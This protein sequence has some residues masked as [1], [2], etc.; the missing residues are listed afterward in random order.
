VALS[1]FED[2]S[3]LVTRY[4]VETGRETPVRSSVVV[5]SAVS[6]V[7]VASAI[8]RKQRM[9][10]L[11]P[12]RARV[13]VDAFLTDLNASYQRPSATAAVTYFPVATST[14]VLDDAVGLVGIHGLRAYDAVQLA[15]AVLARAADPT[16]TE[17]IT[18]DVALH[19][20][21]AAEGFTVN[22]LP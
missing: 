15:S 11:S 14:A 6:Q 10:E 12:S 9:G 18:Y 22:E 20:A 21:A 13:L 5:I 2:A 8:W 3:A 16:L 4:V 7:E 19:R 17:L 1:V